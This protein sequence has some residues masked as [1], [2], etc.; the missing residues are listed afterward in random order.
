M[1]SSRCATT[2]APGLGSSVAR[3]RRH[4]PPCQQRETQIA[5][6]AR[7]RHLRLHLRERG[8]EAV[9]VVTWPR[10][11]W[12]ERI[13]RSLASLLQREAIWIEY[14]WR[15]PVARRVR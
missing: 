1:P 3:I 15:G 10:P 13:R 4:V 8:A 14:V 6:A 5:A 9:E 11:E 7:Q 12:H 2:T